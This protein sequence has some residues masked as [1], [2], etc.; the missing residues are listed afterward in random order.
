VRDLVEL[1]DGSF[2]YVVHDGSVTF[3]ISLSLETVLADSQACG[4]NEFLFESFD[5]AIEL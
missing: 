4:S 5:D 1:L 2:D 3:T